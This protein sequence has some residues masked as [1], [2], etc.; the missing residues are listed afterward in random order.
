M[1]SR[2]MGLFGILRC[3][4]CSLAR[5]GRP[6]GSKYVRELALRQTNASICVASSLFGSIKTE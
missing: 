1:K 5:M 4:G 3:T 6:E 2:I